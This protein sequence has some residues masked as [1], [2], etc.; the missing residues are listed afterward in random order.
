[1]NEKYEV[2]HDLLCDLEKK[3]IKKGDVD[4]AELE[5]LYKLS[6]IITDYETREAM[7]KE[8]MKGGYSQHYPPYMWQDRLSGNSYDGMSRGDYSEEGSY[9][10]G[11]DANTGR[12]VSRDSSYEGSYDRYSRDEAEGQIKHKLE[13]MMSEAKTDKAKNAIRQ[14]IE[15]LR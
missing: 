15:G 1:M 13:E 5:Y 11:R 8:E 9:R 10:R 3:I 7:K 2:I 12:Y 4:P 6:S 14:A